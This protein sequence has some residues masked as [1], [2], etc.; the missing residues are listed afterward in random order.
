M[1]ALA[2]SAFFILLHFAQTHI[3]YGG[4]AED[5]SIWSSQISVVIMLVLIM[6]M[7]NGR[8]GLFWGKKAPLGREAVSFVRRNHGYIFAWAVI[9]GMFQSIF[10]LYAQQHLGLNSQVT[11][12]VLGYVGLLVVIVQAGL[13]GRLTAQFS[14]KQLIF[15][16]T[17]LLTF[18]FVAWALTPSLPV[19]LVVLIPLSLGTGIMNTVI[20]SALTK[21]VYPEEVGG[22]LGL[23]A[24]LE[25]LSRVI[26]PTL[27]GVL[28]GRVGAW[29][30]GILS[31]LLMAWLISFIYWRLIVKPDPPLPAR[32][33][34]QWAKAQA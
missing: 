27:G 1:I 29:A 31:A 18:S 33:D 4:L 9:S 13:I 7:E 20:N 15:A 21:A 12:Y 28:L 3:W 24:S 19:L 8:R 6:L 14:E 22:T 17:I 34:L 2:G 32:D 25:S 16:S 5:V 26:A 30:P 23:S 11:G 10:A